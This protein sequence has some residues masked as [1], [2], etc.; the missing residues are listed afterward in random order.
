MSFSYKPLWKL[1]IDHDLTKKGLMEITGISKSTIEK[2]NKGEYISMEIIERICMQL[3]CNVNDVVKYV[4][5]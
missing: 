1:L 3:H 4:E 5:E 2:M